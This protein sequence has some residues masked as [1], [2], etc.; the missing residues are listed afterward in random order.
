MD[1]AVLI[2]GDTVRSAALLHEVPLGISDPFLYAEAGGERH[3]VIGSLEVP[4]VREVDGLRVHPNEEFDSDGLVRSGLS[5]DEIREEI[6][7][8]AVRSLGIT[9][10]VVPGEFPLRL[11]DRLRAEGVQVRPEVAPFARRRRAKT[12]RELEGIRRAQGA[13]E[14]GMRAAAA[15]LHRR[16][17]ALTSEEVKAAI[18]EEFLAH[19]C[20]FDEFI[21]SHGPQSAIGHHGGSGEILP[22]EPVVIDL[23][24]R[25]TGSGC[26][27]D[28]TRTFV[29]GEPPAK[30]VEFHRLTKEALDRTLAAVR[31]GVTGRELHEL[32]CDVF[33]AAGQPT[34]RS[35]EPGV[36]LDEGFMHGLGHGV[37]LDVHE[38]PTVGM[39]GGNE[40]VPGDVITLEPGLYL[41]GFGGCRLEDLVLVTDDGFENLTDYPYDLTP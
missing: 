6:A 8:R 41:P 34:Q 20:V 15:L 18:A 30:L 23:W 31:P 39:A 11:A 17:G 29:V 1:E 13:A 37:G 22:G 9:R 19:G 4:R 33:E 14:A 16:G 36:P 25:D 12:A 2:Y 24:P 21:V 40:L 5:L 3:V 10:A 26:F 27:A 35:K 38:P 32:A 28:M 7:I